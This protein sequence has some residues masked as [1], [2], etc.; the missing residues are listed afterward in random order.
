M[1]AVRSLSVSL[2]ALAAGVLASGPAQ[3]AT[4]A[5]QF[6]SHAAGTCQGAL[7]V[8]E[9]A[10]R[11][12][13]LAVKNEG[14]TPAFITCSYTSQG[15]DAG[16]SPRNPT[17][18]QVYFRNTSGT[19]QT[20]SCTGVSGYDNT[21]PVAQYIVKSTELG[22]FLG[23]LNWNAADFAGAPAVFPNGLFSISCALAPGVSIQE[24]IV[25]FVEE[26]GTL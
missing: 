3:G 16:S 24:S 6:V 14:T 15:S 19:N 10:I 8:F 17:N 5:R 7:P 22:P 11:K 23:T 4:V 12:R 9:T 21:V 26:V 20:L 25:V 18:V 1:T 2:L 13:P